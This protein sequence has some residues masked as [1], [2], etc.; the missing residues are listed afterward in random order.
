MS[1]EHFEFFSSIIWS[2]DL[3][4]HVQW[5]RL[6]KLFKKMYIKNIILNALLVCDR[7]Y[8]YWNP[9]LKTNTFFFI[10]SCF[11]IIFLF[12][13][14]TMKV[15]SQEARQYYW[16]MGFMSFQRVCTGSSYCLIW[17]SKFPSLTIVIAL[18]S[19]SFCVISVHAIF[20]N[21]YQPAFGC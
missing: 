4:L 16:S 15:G 10:C 18:L 9:I 1:L 14:W 12:I 21:G 7:M 5:K 6:L 2:Y 8:Y 3:I 19:V 20:R 11:Y 17:R 13:F